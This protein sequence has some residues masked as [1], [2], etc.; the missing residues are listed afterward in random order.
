MNID[1]VTTKATRS[2]RYGRHR[3]LY[4]LKKQG[5]RMHRSTLHPLQL[6]SCDY[7]SH[8]TLKSSTMDRLERTL[9]MYISKLDDDV[10]Y[11]HIY[12]L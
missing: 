12:K 2:R 9:F 8:V 7:A 6:F 5:R 4:N 11:H 1:V 3:S 10:L